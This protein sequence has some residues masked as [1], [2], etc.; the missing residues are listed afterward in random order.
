MAER[1]ALSSK[2]H[3][4]RFLPAVARK[5][6][7][8]GVLRDGIERTVIKTKTIYVVPLTI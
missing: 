5:L 4:E 6:V 2:R 8:K 7:E 1:P 3:V